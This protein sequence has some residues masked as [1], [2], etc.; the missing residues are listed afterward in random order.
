ML[1]SRKYVLMEDIKI[2]LIEFDSIFNRVA[3]FALSSQQRSQ[4]IFS[5]FMGN[6]FICTL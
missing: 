6:F 2:S 5:W 1:S 4:A 3:V